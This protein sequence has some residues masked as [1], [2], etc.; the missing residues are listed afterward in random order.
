MKNE[1]RNWICNFTKTGCVSCRDDDGRLN[2]RGRDGLPVT[3]IVGDESVPNVV[4]YTDRNKE[5]G[6]GDSCVW[7]M[8]VEHLGLDEVCGVL[9]KMN[10]DKRAA[11]R[12][13]WQV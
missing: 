10:L 8:K 7:I 6:T 2:H 12:S 11:D 4:V 1:T 9:R 3:L 5:V 13:E